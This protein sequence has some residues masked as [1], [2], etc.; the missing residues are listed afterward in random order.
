MPENRG[1]L[2]EGLSAP[3]L[4][5]LEML[6]R[7]VSDGTVLEGTIQRCDGDLN[8]YLQLGSTFAKIPREEVTA[9]WISG[10]DREIAVLSRVGKQVCFTVESLSADAKGAPTALLSRRKVQEQAM[11]EMRRSLEPGAVVVGKVVRMEPFGAFVDI[12]RGIVAL[13]PTEYISAARIRHPNERFRVGQKILAVVKVFDRENRRITL[14]HKELL[15]TWLENA[16]RFSEGD[17]VRGTVRGVMDYGCFVELA[18]NLSGLTD[19]R[20][21]L[22]EGDGVSVTVRSIR[23]EHRRADLL[24]RDGFELKYAAA[25]KQRVVHIEKRI[26]RGGSDE[27][28]GSVLHKFQQAL[29]LLFVEILDLIQIQQDAAGGQQRPHIRNDVLHVLQGRR[30]GVQTVQ[31]LV[32]PFRDNVGHGGLA[33]A[34]GTV[35]HHVGV[36]P[37]VDQAAQN[38]AGR[39][40]VPLTHNFIQSFRTDL[41]R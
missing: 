31:R 9:P 34:G 33:G 40:Q 38:T 36:G 20:E 23:P 1:Y 22:R 25:G 37:G 30:G 29:L 27:G 13:L 16:S 8:L 3:P 2:P 39:Q 21:D 12:G 35:E 15:G 4:Y 18:P 28:Q 17:T 11:E 10:A 5:T 7:A 6:R 32:G 41:V 19:Q 24:R 14:T 26:F